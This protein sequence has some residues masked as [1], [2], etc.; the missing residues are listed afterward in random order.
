[1]NLK[2]FI[3]VT[4]LFYVSQIQSMCLGD[5]LRNSVKKLENKKIYL[6]LN[7]RPFLFP[8]SINYYEFNS[9][10]E[11]KNK[12]YVKLD[13]GLSKS[14]GDKQLLVFPYTYNKNYGYFINLGLSRR[15]YI[16]KKLSLNS[17]L[18]FLYNNLD[19]YTFNIDTNT[20]IHSYT[21]EGVNM[22]F[23]ASLMYDFT[24][25]FSAKIGYWTPL[26]GFNRYTFIDNQSRNFY[27]NTNVGYPLNRSQSRRFLDFFQINLYYKI[28]LK[29]K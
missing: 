29:T 13:L 12:N 20:T 15:F 8:S 28:N 9:Q 11:F 3:L 17:E 4:F 14:N 23:N 22:N 27:R 21:L 16:L 24:N 5:S 19:F 18:G 2:F 25:H 26:Y 10:F 6:G 7:L 1:M